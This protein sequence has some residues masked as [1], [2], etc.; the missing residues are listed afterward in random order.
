MKIKAYKWSWWAKGTSFSLSGQ[1]LRRV[2]GV[3]YRLRVILSRSNG[4]C[5]MWPRPNLT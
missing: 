1:G 4:K 3:I 5:E 2:K